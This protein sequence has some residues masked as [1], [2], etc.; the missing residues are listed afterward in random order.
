M[1]KSKYEIGKV[2]IFLIIGFIIVIVSPVVFTLNSWGIIFDETTSPIGDTI[3]GITSPIVGLIG[4]VLVYYALKEQITANKII[5]NQLE[6]QKKE[7]IERKKIQ[8]ISYQIDA[9]KSDID[10]FSTVKIISNSMF[11]N[12]EQIVSVS[13]TDAIE[14]FINK[15]AK[16]RSHRDEEESEFSI[17]KLFELKSIIG[18]IKSLLI[19]IENSN[20]TD[21]D[22]DFFKSRL[23]Y[24]FKTKLISSF[25]KNEEFK[26]SNIP[27]CNCGNKHGGIPDEIFNE[28]E[29]VEKLLKLN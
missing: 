11:S 18:L 12:Q 27:L 25:K 6:N 19:L 16:D 23:E 2:E 14:S 21:I 1:N 28:I 13:G 20:I 22:K 24:I 9:I 7:E 3:G 17:P 29:V 5:L 15:M 10:N 26:L 8:H 4:S